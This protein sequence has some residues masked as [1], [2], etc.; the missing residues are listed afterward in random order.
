MA[1]HLNGHPRRVPSRRPLDVLA[2]AS[3]VI[4]GAAA[5]ETDPVIAIGAAQEFALD[6]ISRLLAR[7][8]AGRHVATCIAKRSDDG[9]S[10]LH[11]G[12]AISCSRDGDDSD[13]G[14]G[15]TV[16]DPVAEQ[17]FGALLMLGHLTGEPVGV[18]LRSCPDTQ[19]HAPDHTSVVQGWLVVDSYARPLSHDAIR[20]VA[21]DGSGAGPGA[22]S[23]EAP[24]PETGVR[25]VAAFSLYAP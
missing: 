12:L 17:T 3:A 19:H 2:E 5:L 18:L 21:E 14:N 15:P 24:H 11:A 25:Y 20:A 22:R 1:D 7:V 6:L 10:F 8:G 13:D 4:W 16:L 23:G 9:L